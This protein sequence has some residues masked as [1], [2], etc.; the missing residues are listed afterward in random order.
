MLNLFL[1]LFDFYR[2]DARN[3]DSKLTLGM[4][5]VYPIFGIILPKGNQVITVDC[6][7]ENTGKDLQVS[8][9]CL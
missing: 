3:M 4:F 2:V 5:T 7:A 1:C 6:V 9:I 8:C